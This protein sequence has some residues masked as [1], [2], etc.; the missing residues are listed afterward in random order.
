MGLAL[1]HSHPGSLLTGCHS[2]SLSDHETVRG[3]WL[4]KWCAP[5]VESVLSQSL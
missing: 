3:I 1:N 2:W 5:R 4:G